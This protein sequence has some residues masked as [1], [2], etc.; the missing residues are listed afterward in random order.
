MEF[1]FEDGVTA[2]LRSVSEIPLDQL[3]ETMDGG[4][5]GTTQF[6]EAGIT[7]SVVP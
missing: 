1:N 6:R 7:L 3:T 4:Q 2:T 5:I